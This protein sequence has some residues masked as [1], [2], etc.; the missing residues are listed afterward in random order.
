MRE[1]LS[2][3]VSNVEARQ[4]LND[5]AVA[6]KTEIM[7]MLNTTPE[8]ESLLDVFFGKLG[9]L[10]KTIIGGGGVE[11]SEVEG[12]VPAKTTP[13]PTTGAFSGVSAM[14]G[15][16]PVSGIFPGMSTIS[17]K[18]SVKTGV[19]T[20]KGS[21]KKFTP[22]KLGISFPKIKTT[23]TKP[24]EI[25]PLTKPTIKFGSST[26]KKKRVGITFGKINPAHLRRSDYI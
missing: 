22:K 1:E 12:L 10:I 16:I 9:E 14:V 3:P 8:T 23:V 21:S 4:K 7:Q 18:E 17:S 11:A 15:K 26:K 2:D 13:T 19:S 24:V 5:M 25:K 20:K 6:T